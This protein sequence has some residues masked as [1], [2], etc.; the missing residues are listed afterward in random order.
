MKDTALQSLM[1]QLKGIWEGNESPTTLHGKELQPGGFRA[2]DFILMVST[3]QPSE[4]S[5]TLP[6]AIM[7][8]VVK[9]RLGGNGQYLVRPDRLIDALDSIAGNLP[10]GFTRIFKEG[11]Q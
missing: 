6:P 9:G 4:R 2:G 10:K 1:D 8:H 3:P 7:M 5:K 11:E